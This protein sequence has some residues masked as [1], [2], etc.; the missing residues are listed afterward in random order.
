MEPDTEINSLDPAFAD[1]EF[2]STN[3]KRLLRGLF[4]EQ[5]SSDKSTVMYTLKDEDHLGYPSLGRLYLE[6]HDP[7]EYTF[8]KTYLESWDHWVALTEATWFKPYLFRWRKELEMK[9]KAE[10]LSLI[11]KESRN[12]NSKAQFAAARFL[13]E[14]GWEPKEGQ[15]SRGR[16][17]KTDIA[18]ATNHILETDSRMKEDFK[19]L[20][21]IQ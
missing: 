6:A 14:R 19:R 16:P 11:V 10:A 9:I 20:G 7:S 21:I 15:H 5:T 12:T 8:A 17:S 1:S 18:K 2:R 4:Y 3:R 13:L